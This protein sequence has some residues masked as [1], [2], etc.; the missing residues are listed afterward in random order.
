MLFLSSFEFLLCFKTILLHLFMCVCTRSHTRVCVCVAVYVLECSCGSQRT[1]YR[2]SLPLP[3]WSQGLNLNY[4]AWQQMPL[5]AE[6]SLWLSSLKK[7]INSLL[8]L[9]YCNQHN[10]MVMSIIMQPMI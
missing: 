10:N 7:K 9:R 4:Q 8:F 5:S 3:V 2:S 6:P 1:A